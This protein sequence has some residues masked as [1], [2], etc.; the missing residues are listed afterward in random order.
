MPSPR[1]GGLIQNPGIGLHKIYINI[2]VASKAGLKLD[3][4]KLKFGDNWTGRLVNTR[5]CIFMCSK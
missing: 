3:E 4:A 1:G 5:E 2:V